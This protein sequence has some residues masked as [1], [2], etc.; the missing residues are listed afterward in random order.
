MRVEDDTLVIA[1]AHG[2]PMVN[3]HLTVGEGGRMSIDYDRFPRAL[4]NCTMGMR[5]SYRLTIGTSNGD[6]TLP[7]TST[8]PWIEAIDDDYAMADAGNRV[9]MEALVVE[10]GQCD[11]MPSYAC[12]PR[13]VDADPVSSC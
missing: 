1:V 7:V 12:G 8:T 5:L 3:F 4:L 9:G 13:T 10:P 6:P 11:V 2:D